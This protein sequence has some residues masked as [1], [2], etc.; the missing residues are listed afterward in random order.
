MSGLHICP[1][2]VNKLF[3]LLNTVKHGKILTDQLEDIDWD[4]KPQQE[5][6]IRGPSLPIHSHQ[7]PVGKN[8]IQHR[9]ATQLTGDT[10]RLIRYNKHTVN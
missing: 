6:T 5:H 9:S 1:Q 7:S 4:D 8:L 2:T 10:F 3:F